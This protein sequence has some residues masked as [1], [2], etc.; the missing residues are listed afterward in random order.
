[1]KNFVFVHGGWH[2]AAHWHKVVLLLKENGQH[3]VAVDLPNGDSGL[4]DYRDAVVAAIDDVEGPVTLVGHSL[5]GL[6]ITLVGETIPQAI[7]RLV[8]VSAFVPV[9]LPSSAAYRVLPENAGSSTT[10][11]LVGEP[12]VTFRID[13]KSDDTSYLA[14]IRDVFYHDVSADVFDECVTHLVPELPARVTVEDARGT[15]ERW[16]SL[17]RTFV[18]CT[19]DR[20]LVIALQDR[21]IREADEATPNNPFE[22]HT[23]PAGHSPF[24]SMPRE[25]SEILAAPNDSTT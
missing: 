15:S 10:S 2:S 9:R 22:V 19:N 4:R 17:P 25:L 13:P 23:L 11:V 8:Y 16:G 18:R 1:M 5:G 3:A 6:T 24:A 12:G 20:A 21:M 14:R 7:E